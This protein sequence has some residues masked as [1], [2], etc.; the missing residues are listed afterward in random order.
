MTFNTC[1]KY[2]TLLRFQLIPEA[3]LIGDLINPAAFPFGLVFVSSFWVL[4]GL[5]SFKKTENSFP[6][7]KVYLKVGP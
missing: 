4:P 5:S 6:S 2:L 1:Q 3:Y 7:D